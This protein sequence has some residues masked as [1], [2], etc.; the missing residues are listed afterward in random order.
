MN[1]RKEEEVRIFVLNWNARV[2][3]F[4]N[5]Q[6]SEVGLGLIDVVEIL[7][8]PAKRL[9]FRV[10]NAAGVNA[11]FL[12]HGFV[13]SSEVLADNSDYPNIGE[14][15]GRQREIRGS[16]AEK[17]VRFAGWSGDVIECNRTDDKYAHEFV[18]KLSI[19]D[20]F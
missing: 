12:E 14:V 20:I 8:A 6:I 5:I 9:A 10:L 2:K 3:V 13:L 19:R 1:V 18:L 11:S 16:A 7:T 15:A 4:K 17:I